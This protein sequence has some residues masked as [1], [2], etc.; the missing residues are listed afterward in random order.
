MKNILRIIFPILMLLTSNLSI[1][2]NNKK[3]ESRG[4]RE[5][6]G[7]DSSVALFKDIGFTIFNELTEIYIKDQLKVA[8]TEIFEKIKKTNISCKGNLYIDGVKKEAINYPYRSPTLIELDCENWTKLSFYRQVRLVI[9]EFL[10]L[11]L[12]NDEDFFQSKLIYNNYLEQFAKHKEVFSSILEDSIVYCNSKTFSDQLISGANIY[13][14]YNSNGFN[15][16]NLAVHFGCIPIIEQV[17][18]ENANIGL[19]NYEILAT[20]LLQKDQ[21]FDLKSSINKSDHANGV[22][23]G[24]LDTFKRLDKNFLEFKLQSEISYNQ[25]SANGFQLEKSNIYKNYYKCVPSSSFQHLIAYEYLASG[26]SDYL[27][28]LKKLEDVGFNLGIKNECNDTA[29]SIIERR[30]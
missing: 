9:H 25:I 27:L 4:W 11:L 15:S 26:H 21:L 3:S 10:H 7:G 16:I 18:E 30:K 12:V 23:F 8:K 24:I 22:L 2:D 28:I 19:E 20:K 5:S 13:A 1:A 14:R 6:Y 17:L 29:R